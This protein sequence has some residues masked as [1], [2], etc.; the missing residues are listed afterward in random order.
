M[1]GRRLI[2]YLSDI[3]E[4]AELIAQLGLR[5][6]VIHGYA[7]VNLGTIFETA[8][9][10]I[11]E[12]L[13]LITNLLA[14][15]RKAEIN[16]VEFLAGLES[17]VAALTEELGEPNHHISGCALPGGTDALPKCEVK[18]ASNQ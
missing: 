4:S 1:S 5:N 17:T 9:T 2:D 15:S 16:R 7:T 6:A 13:V 18:Q 14:P 12:L 10:D 11:P 3:V 8:V